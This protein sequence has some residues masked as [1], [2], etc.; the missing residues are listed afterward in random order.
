MNVLEFQRYRLV[1]SDFLGVAVDGI[2][3]FRDKNFCLERIILSRLS[4]RLIQ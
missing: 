3:W 1:I 2:Q 4:N